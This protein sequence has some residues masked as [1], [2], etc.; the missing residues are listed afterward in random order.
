MA[1][2]ERERAFSHLQWLANF[3]LTLGDRWLEQAASNLVRDLRNARDNSAL[4]HLRNEARKLTRAS[5]SAP[6]LVRR[7]HG[8]GVLSN[9]SPED[10]DGPVARAAGLATD[11]RAADPTY[12]GLGFRPVTIQGSDALARLRVRLMEVEQS[13][14]LIQALEASGSAPRSEA[15]TRG[16]GTASVETARGAAILHVEIDEGRVVQVELTTP[17]QRLSN[18][19]AAVADDRELSDAL[20]GIASLDVSPWEVDR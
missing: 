1:A 16:S 6:L 2:L 12:L 5:Y 9:I 11:A 20:L 4:R 7:L 8:C 17:S 14:E 18:L 15:S 13:L 10:L 19:V 3:S